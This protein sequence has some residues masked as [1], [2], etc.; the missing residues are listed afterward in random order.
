M[1]DSVDSIG[2]RIAEYRKLKGWNQ[3]QLAQAVGYSLSLVEKIER[4]ARGIER[5]SVL[6]TFARALSVDISELTGEVSRSR[7]QREHATIPEIRRVMTALPYGIEDGPYRSIPE[8]RRE[9]ESSIAKRESGKY[10]RFGED[11]PVLLEELSR[12]APS[13]GD[14][15]AAVQGLIAE[16]LHSGSMLLRRLGYVDLSWVAIQQARSAALQS[17]DP[18]LLIA[19]DWQ[20][21]EFYFRTGNTLSGER[22]SEDAIRRLEESH[23]SGTPA[24]RA[25]S[26][27]GT[28]HL[29]RSMAAAQRVERQE[30]EDAISA[31]AK[32][33]DRNRRDRDDYQSQFGPSNVAV[34]GVAT[35]VE[36]GDGE[37]AAR[38]AKKVD[39]N[40]ILSRERQARY[41]MDVARAYTQTRKDAAALTVISDAYK[42]APEYV[43][44]HV[45]AREVV[46]ELLERERRSITPG[47]RTLAKKLGVA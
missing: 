18:L 43:A 27:V 35:A 14:E 28:F 13:A 40:A 29:L 34:F 1:I 11:L 37:L 38:R 9:V 32:A 42:R 7:K 44:N 33:A 8:L 45:M 22:L 16:T 47:L 2:K 46:A 24:P 31:A 3:R 10:T 12:A 19:N 21:V 25:V 17:D 39:T 15:A 5:Y 41:L 4:G 20:M 23:L 36:M 30:V 26:L 6:H